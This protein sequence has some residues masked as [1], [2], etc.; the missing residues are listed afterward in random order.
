MTVIDPGMLTSVQTL[1]SRPCPVLGVPSAGAGDTLSVKVGNR[2]LGN[3]DYD[4]ALECTLTGVTVRLDSDSHI[5]VTGGEAD[6]FLK[7]DSIRA[8]ERWKVHK[9]GAGET[10]QIGGVRR[11]AR[12]Y[13]CVRGGFCSDRNSFGPSTNLGAGFGGFGG[14]AL[15]AG[16]VLTFNGATG[17]P[18]ENLHVPPMVLELL[19]RRTLRAIALPMAGRFEQEAANLFWQSEFTV[20]NQSDRSGIRLEGPAIPSLC[21]GRMISEGMTFGAIEI[22][23]SGQP[24]VLGVE[25]PTTGGYPVIACVATVD[26]PILGQ[27]RPREKVRFEQLTVAEAH[28]LLRSASAALR[29]LPPQRDY[30]L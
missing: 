5:V 11:G 9:V 22:P 26:L 23:Q 21:A 17:D 7:G 2:L 29:R 3:H 28:R 27:L 25:H 4:A 15:R 8:M 24:I 19:E 30:S 16:D 1:G 12:V 13:L 18:P 20:S 6:C 14:R 10:V